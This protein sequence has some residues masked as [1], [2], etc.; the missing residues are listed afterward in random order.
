VGG[1]S[2]GDELVDNLREVSGHGGSGDGAVQRD[3]QMEFLW[4]T[5]SRLSIEL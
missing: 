1:G 4:D 2:Q 5:T 3:E